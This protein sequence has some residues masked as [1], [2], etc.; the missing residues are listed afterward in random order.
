MHLSST[1][2]PIEALTIVLNKR[3]W[4]QSTLLSVAVYQSAQLA[5]GHHMLQT[6][7]TCH[8]KYYTAIALLGA[9]FVATLF[10]SAERVPGGRHDAVSVDPHPSPW[11]P[12]T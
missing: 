10:F 9:L 1:I 3:V 8:V 2:R 12:N 5:K 7:P 6:N 11:F 4:K